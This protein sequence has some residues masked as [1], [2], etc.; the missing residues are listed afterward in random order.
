MHFP[1][2]LNS[3]L[4]SLQ[5]RKGKDLLGDDNLEKVC[6]IM[7]DNAALGVAKLMFEEKDILVKVLK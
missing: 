5:A 1:L 3:K 4:L 7:A 6:L 2:A